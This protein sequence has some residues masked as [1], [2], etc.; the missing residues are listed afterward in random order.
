MT[1][2]TWDVPAET[3]VTPVPLIGFLGL[4]TDNESQPVHR[5][6]WELFSSNR[7][8]DRH[9]LNF[10]ILNLDSLELPVAKPPRTSY[11]WYLP[12]GILK[13]NWMSKHLYSLPSVI[14]LFFSNPSTSSV[15]T[16]V[17]KLRHSLT[18][19][20]TKLAVVLLQDSADQ[21]TITSICTECSIPARAVFCLSPSVSSAKPAILEFEETLQELASNYYHGQIKTVKSHRD[22]LNKATHLQLLVRHSFKIGFLSEVKGDLNSAYKS[23]TSAYLLLLES[24]LTE[25][26]S[27]ELR[28][29][30]GI[31][32]YKICK[33]AFKLNLPRDA[34]TQFRKH[35]EQWRGPPCPTLLSWEHAAWQSCQAQHF[36]QLFLE[37]CK[38][39]QT[40]IQTQ[41]P[42]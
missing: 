35:L 29:V 12:R 23:Y 34:I 21:D 32:N 31:L 40:A 38:A 42:G 26:N 39:G 2:D 37:A 27:C 9:A 8:L 36:A 24:R 5:K 30:A 3:L 11:E 1:E 4:D 7:G 25:H 19:R 10:L 22:H 17:S 13:R 33:L 18:N 14:V 20:Q 15:S 41:H 6:V 28:S 16:V